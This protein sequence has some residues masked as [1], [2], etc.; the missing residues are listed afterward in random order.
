MNELTASAVDWL[1]RSDEPGVRLQA[2]HDL[3]DEPPAA[4]DR[5]L[6]GPRLSALL[7]G[8]QPD[9]G[10]GVPPYTKWSGAHWRLVSLVELGV[11]AGEP[12]AVAAA[13]TVLDWL[14]SPRRRVFVVDGLAR[15]C[16]SMEGNGLAVSVRLGLADDPRV[17]QLARSLVAWQW[18]DGGWNCDAQATG[19]RSS[20]HESLIPMW[21]LHEYAVATGASWAG[22]AAGR[23]AELILD[24]RVFRTSDGTRVIKPAWL[25]PRYPPYW[26]VDVLQ[27]LLVLSRMGKAA[28]PRAAEAVD[29]VRG[30]RGPDRRWRPAGYWWTPPGGGKGLAEV[31]DWG[32]REPCEML[33]LNA[34][35]VLR[36]AGDPALSR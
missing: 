18:P 28:D 36:A 29:V 33:T 11:P 7:C 34:L 35:R 22:E 26:H 20:F 24:H 16:A 31:V 25:S 2:R 4:Q 3:L 17:E 30:R 32:R 9:G 23:T 21:G 6:D 5:A 19:R 15:R 1:L 13:D 10:F 8:Q 12:R 27:A 14:A